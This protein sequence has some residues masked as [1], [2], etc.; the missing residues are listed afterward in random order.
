[1]LLQQLQ[2]PSLLNSLKVCTVFLDMEP[3][4]VKLQVLNITLNI[5]HWLLIL[6]LLSI[7]KQQI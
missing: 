1:M 5:W 6:R 4:V 7:F 2:L 3:P